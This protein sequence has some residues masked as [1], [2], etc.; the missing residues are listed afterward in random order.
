MY[1]AWM[2]HRKAQ[3]FPN[4][5]GVPKRL[6]GISAIA[7]AASSED[8]VPVFLAPARKPLRRRCVSKLPGKRLL[9]VTFLSATLRATPARKAVRPAR[10]AL[11]RV[12]TCDGHLDADGRDIDDSPE[13]AGH[14]GVNDFLDEFDGRHHVHGDA[15][16]HG[17]PIQF[18][19]IPER[20]AA[21]V[22]DQN[23]GRR[24]GCQ[25]RLLALRGGDIGD[26]RRDRRPRGSPDFLGA[27][28]EQRAVAAIDH[29]RDAGLGQRA[30]A[31]RAPIPDSMR[32]RSP[33]ARECL[34]P[35][36]PPLAVVRITK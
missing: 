14:H 12:Q 26:H 11:D 20:R 22:V 21:V 4:S 15:G 2:L 33:I 5:A 24:A 6:A 34:N 31:A 35:C 19:K 23:I 1:P 18:A 8:G 25:Q 13:A 10:A 7:C 36:D 16:K 9:M 29:Q 32:R 17:L 28:L 3:V 27:L 30:G